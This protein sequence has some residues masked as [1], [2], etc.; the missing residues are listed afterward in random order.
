[1]TIEEL[2]VVIKA[3]ISNLKKSMTDAKQ[4]LK[5]V[6]NEADN[7]QE[8]VKSIDKVSL[9][10]LKAQLKA[11]QEELKNTQKA[12]ADTEASLKSLQKASEKAIAS[13][14]NLFGEKA[15]PESRDKLLS[16]LLAQD[17]Q[18]QEINRKIEEEKAKLESLVSLQRSQTEEIEKTKKAI[19]DANSAVKNV[20]NST[21]T[22]NT[23]VKRINKSLNGVGAIFKRLVVKKVLSAIIKQ[24]K[25]MIPLLA[26]FDKSMG[27]VLGYNKALSNMT[28]TF[29]KLSANV[30]VAFANLMVTLEPVLTALMNAVSSIVE[31]FNNLFAV[32][33][34]KST[35]TRA[36]PDY[37][38]DYAESLQDSEKEAK[39]LYTLIAGFD[40][41]NTL[42]PK[43]D[44]DKNTL[45]PEDMFIEEPVDPTAAALT[46]LGLLASLLP[47]L[48]SLINKL[49]NAF[50]GK[51]DVLKD[52][53]ALEGLARQGLLDL[54]P[55]LSTV[56]DLVKALGTSWALAWAAS[57]ALDWG[58]VT[59]WLEVWKKSLAGAGQKVWDWVTETSNA[60]DTWR[61]KAY[62]TVNNWVVETSAAFETWR[63][64]IASTLNAWATN[65]ANVMSATFTNAFNNLSVWIENT[66]S[67]LVVWR[68]RWLETVGDWSVN[69]ASVIGQWIA[70][71][72]NSM[73][74]W[75]ANTISVLAQWATSTATNIGQWGSTMVQNLGAAF[76]SGL[77][78]IGSF[79]SGA[80]SVVNNLLSSMSSALSSLGSA[81]VQSISN[82]LSTA[83]QNV[84]NF[85][86][87]LRAKF[88]SGGS[89]GSFNP[90]TR[91]TNSLRAMAGILGAAAL[92]SF[93]S[94]AARFT[95]KQFA[96]GG[97]YA[98]GGV[99]SSPTLGLMGEYAGASTNPEIVAPQSMLRDIIQENNGELVNAFAQMTQQIISAI[100]NVDMEV[101]VGD[102]VIAQSAARGNRQY[103]N[104]TGRE[105]ITV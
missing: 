3:Q 86:S 27:N 47:G 61:Q 54:A 6:S 53:N 48:I 96:W 31:Q 52:Q 4:D 2:K 5:G 9:D 104:M 68:Q 85:F 69:T 18:L 59:D 88:N 77:E 42:N 74:T 73:V 80:L 12:A 16:Q 91:M 34:G 83:W 66:I 71:T 45:N 75:S 92:G 36:N 90:I 95:P 82:G 20:D 50:K 55:A 57:K 7:T 81:I 51:N 29:R 10:A 58:W 56:T 35:Y 25:E 1:M 41:L 105:L 62:S 65:L 103:Y 38:K 101:T 60:F 13:Y 97:A 32:L 78:T 94:F 39:K 8:H 21:K 23:S 17:P 22:I 93:K 102:D 98:N 24:I 67:S 76:S 72:W 64:N 40:E 11:Q 30:T 43:D 14:S 84:I 19:E 63:N 99:I 26:R 46:G 100:N 87:N 49:K 70:N 15:D 37:W 89:Q 33:S 44:K 79:A 28:S